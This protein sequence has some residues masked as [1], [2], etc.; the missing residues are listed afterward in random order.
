LIG[1][2]LGVTFIK[3]KL[4]IK[5]RIGNEIAPA[6]ALGMAIGRIGCFLN[7]CCYGIPTNCSYGINFGDGVLRY[8]T[9]LFEA[10]FDL[11]MF[12]YIIKIKDK[13]TEP[14][15]LFKLFASAYFTYRFFIEFIRVEPRVFLGLTG[16]QI[17]ALIGLIYMNKNIVL[18]D[19]GN[20]K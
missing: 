11:I 10:M 5:D 13:V 7:G 8:P 18:G 3:R 9:Q 2:S 16:F 4:N 1:G 17:G 19:V 12:V 15:K 20:G 6:A 14:G